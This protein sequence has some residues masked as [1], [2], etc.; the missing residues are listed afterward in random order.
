M[1]LKWKIVAGEVVRNIQGDECAVT[2]MEVLR[3]MQC[4]REEETLVA[5]LQGNAV[6]DGRDTRGDK[7]M[8]KAGGLSRY[9]P[10]LTIVF[11]SGGT[12]QTKRC[13]WQETLT[14][15]S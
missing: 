7:A 6:E 5:A 3:V 15:L 12:K 4:T 10:A 13:T 14:T 1:E 11:R 9:A 2:C 8:H